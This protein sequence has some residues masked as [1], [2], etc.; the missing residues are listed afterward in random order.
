MLI[1]PFS[2]C[3]APEEASV[4]GENADGSRCM[5]TLTKSKNIYLAFSSNYVVRER[6]PQRGMACISKQIIYKSILIHYVNF[7]YCAPAVLANCF[8]VF[9]AQSLF[10]NDFAFCLQIEIY[11]FRLLGC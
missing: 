9:P 11:V 2:A 5:V 3:K 8:M 4:W 10:G 1:G 7:Q 6:A